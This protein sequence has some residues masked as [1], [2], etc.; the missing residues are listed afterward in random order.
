MYDARA[1]ANFFLDHAQQRKLPLTIMTLLKV[2]Y[3]AHGWHLAKF[4]KP[5]IAQPFEAWKH[6]PVSRVVYEQF[7]GYKNKPLDKKAF[8]FDPRFMAL[9]PTPYR[10]EVETTELLTSVFEYYTRFH[11]FVLSDLTHERGGPWY[12]IWQEAQNRAVPGMIIPNDLILDWFRSGKFAYSTHR[13]Q[14]D[15][16]GSGI[17]NPNPTSS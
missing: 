2:L 13:E 9:T 7:K 11:A 8:S 14:G 10:F 5:L 17:Q 15:L 16:N 1:V 3:F 4:E 12:Q 6:G